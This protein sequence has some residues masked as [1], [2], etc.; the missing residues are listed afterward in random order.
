M[1]SLL[2]RILNRIKKEDLFEEVLTFLIIIF[3]CFQK[4]GD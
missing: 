2:S 4:T 1:I 3:A